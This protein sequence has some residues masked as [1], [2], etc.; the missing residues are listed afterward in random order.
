LPRK[1]Y[2]SIF[3][4]PRHP[5]TNDVIEICHKETRKFILEKISSE[6]N[7]ANLLNILLDANHVHNFN[8]HSVTKFRP[9]GLINNTNEEIFNEVIANITKKY[10]KKNLEYTTIKKDTKLRLQPGCIK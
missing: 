3:S 9:M 10:N 1:Q 4:S 8:I 7:K 6:P 2:N 5:Q